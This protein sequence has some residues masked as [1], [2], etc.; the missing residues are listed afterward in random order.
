[1]VQGRYYHVRTCEDIFIL[2]RFEGLG[3]VELPSGEWVPAL[4][5]CDVHLAGNSF[6]DVR[7]PEWTVAL[8]DIRGVAEA[9]F[10][11]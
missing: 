4:G 1:M 5:L 3:E 6:T 10:Q 2:G 11:D 9:D 7:C 8:R